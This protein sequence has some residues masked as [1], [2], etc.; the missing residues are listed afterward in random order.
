[1]SR[2]ADDDG[3]GGDDDDDDEQLQ[4]QKPLFLWRRNFQLVP[5]WNKWSVYSG[6]MLKSNDTSWNELRSTCNDF[7][8]NFYVV[9]N[10]TYLASDIQKKA[11]RIWSFQ[12]P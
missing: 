5:R 12:L 4:K 2:S 9:G 7:S 3:G 8:F 11:F 10:V 1:M 6:I